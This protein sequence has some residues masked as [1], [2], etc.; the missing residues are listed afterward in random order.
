M[1]A[2]S[3]DACLIRQRE[4]RT[5]LGDASRSLLSLDLDDDDEL[6]ELQSTLS[7]E[8][9]DHSLKLK[10]LL[11][12]IESAAAAAMSSTPDSKGVKLP[13]IDVLQRQYIEL[14]DLGTVLCHCSQPI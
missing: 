8:V 13:K 7:G 4:I 12:V 2:E 1:E 5:E 11:S 9:F 10:R 3:S 14:E 6:V